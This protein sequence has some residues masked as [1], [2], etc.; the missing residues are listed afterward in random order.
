MYDPER[1]H[2]FSVLPVIWVISFNA[3]F[4]VSN[5]VLHVV[6]EFGAHVVERG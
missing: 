4:V 3:P 6:K 1:L 2:R 5:K